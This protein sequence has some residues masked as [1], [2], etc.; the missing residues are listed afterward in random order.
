MSATR[1][2]SERIFSEELFAD[3]SAA[4][5]FEILVLAVHAFFHAL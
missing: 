2:S 5:G 3:I 1:S 4:L